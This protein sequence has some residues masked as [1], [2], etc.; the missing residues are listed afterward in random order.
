LFSGGYQEVALA[1]EVFHD[2]EVLGD[3]GVFVELNFIIIIVKQNSSKFTLLFNI[4]HSFN[5]LAIGIVPTAN[6]V[7]L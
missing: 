4:C 5:V 2:D 7:S 3:R 6:K 1:K